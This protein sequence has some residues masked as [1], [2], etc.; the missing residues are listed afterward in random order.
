MADYVTIVKDDRSFIETLLYKP[1]I[2]DG[3]ECETWWS[4]NINDWD[5]IS[6]E[7]PF[8]H[9]WGCPQWPRDIIG[10]RSTKKLSK[11]K[12]LLLAQELLELCGIEMKLEVDE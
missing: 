7:P 8:S 1:K 3:E 12:A 10:F 11:P 4:E 2:I 9:E 6:R 5:I